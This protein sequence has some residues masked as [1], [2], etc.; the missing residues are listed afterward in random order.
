LATSGIATVGHLMLE[1]IKLVA[2]VDITHVP[3]KGGGQV[4]TDAAGGQ[5]ELFTSNPSP[6]VNALL[7]QGRMRVL[8]V[9]AP[10]RLTTMPNVPTLSEL[11]YPDSNLTS[12]FGVFAPSRTPEAV[13]KR[14]NAEINKAVSAP[15]MTDRLVKLDNVPLPSSV[16]SFAK[17]I[18]TEY[19]ANARIVAKAQIRVD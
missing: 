8:A 9:A 14:L 11:G 10:Q 18:R 13:V 15:D 6:G 19:E 2:G 17:T 5:F 12:Q 3:Y 1:Q 7:S 4:I 16:E